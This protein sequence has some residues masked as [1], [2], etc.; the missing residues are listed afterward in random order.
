MIFVALPQNNKDNENR[1]KDFDKLAPRSDLHGFQNLTNQ[2]YSD[3]QQP[4]YSEDGT[5]SISKVKQDRSGE[6]FQN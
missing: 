5:Q 4:R 2:N 6:F 1:Q 3:N